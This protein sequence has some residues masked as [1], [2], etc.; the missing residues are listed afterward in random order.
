[1]KRSVVFILISITFFLIVAYGDDENEDAATTSVFED[2]SVQLSG[3]KEPEINARSAIV[4]DFESGRVLYEKNAY[5]KRPMASTT[6]V[7]TA[8][9][10]LENGNLDDMVTVSKKASSIRGST[11]NLYTG[12]VLTLREL[13]YGLLLC[14]GNDA[15]IAIAEHISGSVDG[16]LELMNSKALE[17]G[18]LNT[19]FTTTHG[20]DQDGHY[21]TAYDMALITRYA[22]RNPVFNEIVKTSS[23]QIGSRHMYNT[24]EMLVSYYGADGV[25]TGYTGKAGRC[26]IT[27]ATRDNRRFI[28]VVLFCDSRNQRALSSKKILDYAF[29]HYY[30]HTLINGEYICY[31]PVYKGDHK[32]VPVY[33]EKTITMPITDQEKE[34]LYRKTSLP[35]ILYAP[36]QQKEAVG[37]V[38][39][40]LD[41]K[42]LCESVIRAGKMI[43]QKTILHNILDVFILWLE[44][45]KYN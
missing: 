23:I 27:S 33:V 28:S 4:M 3:D 13:M 20:L 12:E 21:S 30:P 26:L 35:D 18:A 22:L 6:K 39:I 10:A 40:Y 16:F 9:V 8:I 34:R 19:H 36:V 45:I 41:D 14:S 37:T 11:M 38:S 29:S 5:T 32:Q 15:S 2:M 44:M 24:N 31:L 7:M 17:I 43:K 1:L 25:K 42:I